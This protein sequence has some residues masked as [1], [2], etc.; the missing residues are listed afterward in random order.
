MRRI[1]SAAA[2]GL[3]A[4]TAVTVPAIADRSKPSVPPVQAS[5]D[6]ITPQSVRGT[7]DFRL[8]GPNV[9][10]DQIR[11]EIDGRTARTGITH[12]TFRFRHHKPATEG[13][14]GFTS[15]G[16]GEITCLRVTGS[17]ALVTAVIAHETVPG[18]PDGI[19]PHAYYLR[20][21]DGSADKVQ[22]VQGPPPPAIAGCTDP[23]NNPQAYVDSSV[24]DRGDFVLRGL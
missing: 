15:Y 14:P 19:G 4:L 7:G 13:D 23:L 9:E 21:S 1:L 24:L 5:S 11:F 8:H 20:V 12:G 10:G 16:D 2:V 17:S 6:W 18:M 22:F 3:A